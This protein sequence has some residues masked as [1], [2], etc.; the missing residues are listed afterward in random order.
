MILA[1]AFEAEGAA[2]VRG[3]VTGPDGAAVAGATVVLSRA[4]EMASRQVSGEQGDYEFAGIEPGVYSLRVTIAGFRA[5]MAERLIVG[6]DAHLVNNVEMPAATVAREVSLVEPV[7]EDY[8]RF[9]GMLQ[10]AAKQNRWS[11]MRLTPDVDWMP[12]QPRQGKEDLKAR[13]QWRTVED[14]TEF[15]WRLHF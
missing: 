10:E 13:V 1:L 5:Y 2:V 11:E 4:G 7:R 12:A 8:S 15:R 3:R 14:R 6:R 9:R